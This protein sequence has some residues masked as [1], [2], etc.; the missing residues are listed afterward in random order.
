MYAADR[1]E[2]I[3]EVDEHACA[4]KIPEANTENEQ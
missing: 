4:N 3:T 2:K 1:I